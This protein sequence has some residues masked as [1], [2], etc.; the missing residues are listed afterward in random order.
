MMN[1]KTYGPIS[2]DV[3]SNDDLDF[4]FLRKEGI[5]KIQK[6]GS[7]LWTD[8]NTHDPGVTILEVL[9]YAITD[10]GYR[11]SL[12]VQDLLFEGDKKSFLKDHFHLGSDVLPCK[13]LTE[14]DYRMLFI[15]LK[16]VRNCWLEP[17]QQTLYADCKN[18]K[19]SYHPEV[20]EGIAPKDSRSFELKG[21]HRILVD[22]EEEVS[23]ELVKKRIRKSY[24]ENRNL[25][26]DLVEVVSVDE[27]PIQVCAIIELEAE[28]DEEWI[29]ASI[30]QAIRQYFSPDIRFY[31]FSEML[32]KG[33]TTDQIFE[34]PALKHGFLDPEEV[35]QASLR[36]EI[37]QSDIIQLIMDLEGVTAIREI[38]INHC[39]QENEDGGWV[40][41]VDP[42]KKPVLCDKSKFNFFKG[43][44][45]VNVNQERVANYKEVL[46]KEQ[47]DLQYGMKEKSYS[48]PEP[49][50]Y[51]LG[52]YASIR[53]DFPEVYGVGPIGL[54]ETV[55]P[56]WKRKANQL[57]AYL[58]FFDQVLVSYFQHLSQVKSLLSVFTTSE[59]TYFT[60]TV[61]DIGDHNE[62]LIEG[63]TTGDLNEELFGAF[64]EANARNQKIKDH[65]LARFAEKF[66]DYAFLMKKIYGTGIDQQVLE[67][68]SF[69]LKE[70]GK[71][72]V[73]R[74]TAMN[75]YQQ[76]LNRIWDSDNTS[77]FEKRVALLAGIR[78]FMRK[79]LAR[80]FVEIYPLT[81]AQGDKVYRWRIYDHN[82]SILLTATEEYPSRTAA[83]KEIYL[84]I[85][86][87]KGF[88]REEISSFFNGLE[89]IQETPFSLGCFRIT[90]S[91][92]GRFSFS[93]IDP[94]ITDTDDPDY[95]IASQYRYYAFQ[96]FP[97]AVLSFKDF[98]DREFDDEGLFLVENILLRP[99]VDE[100]DDT[101]NTFL[102]FC[103]ED[104][105][106]GNCLDPYSFRVTLVLPGNT[107]RFA[108][109]D[110]RDFL[111]NLIRE[112]L[113]AHILAKICWIGRA[114]TGDLDQEDQLSLFE[115]AYLEF[116]KG[117]SQGTYE[118][119]GQFIKILSELRSI[120]PTGTLY[121]CEEEDESNALRDSI[122]LGRTNLGTI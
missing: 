38:R 36:K 61:T 107:F 54:P 96:N 24:H 117:L 77:G 32:D 20:L 100:E 25:C 66:S 81:N 78:N 80:S 89:E 52:E 31:S 121:N 90:Q 113:P 88:S 2:K 111:E 14:L 109:R 76:P 82:R 116:L 118:N 35:K 3:H 74:S 21:L 37:R 47:H 71:I 59:K 8:F 10:L 43:L 91:P 93:I 56:E 15:D 58:S 46:R 62:F 1:S 120:Y 51:P 27:H 34:G 98:M 79:N 73:E 30:D 72:S 65:L 55:D 17:Y 97:Q 5:S 23:V 99:N 39:E 69:F 40:I 108:D 7:G 26:E 29:A 115:E 49:Y 57:K 41:A 9:C 44:L 6:L 13:A 28:A 22:V 95:I 48:L 83:H 85:Q 67:T 60:R 75:Y 104:C 4:Q 18:L 42:G 50:S 53:N 122:I 102:P 112:E 68:K 92:S 19:M 12:P 45:P 64:D 103:K 114:N 106:P 11:L 87:V 101:N 33:Y 94:S 16:G 86:L 110:F 119:H 63:Y 84:V 70:Y 105:Q